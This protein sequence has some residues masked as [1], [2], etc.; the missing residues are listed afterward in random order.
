MTITE[1]ELHNECNQVYWKYIAK[2]VPYE[3]SEMWQK[4]EANG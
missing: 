3:V 4:D 1:L 2:E